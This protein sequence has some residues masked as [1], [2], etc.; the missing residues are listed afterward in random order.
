MKKPSSKSLQARKDKLGERLRRYELDNILSDP[1]LFDHTK[2]NYID[3]TKAAERLL[4]L[5]AVSFTAYNFGESEKVMNWLKTEELWQSV[6]DKEKEFFRDPDPS[7]EE[8]KVLSWRFEGAYVLAWCLEKIEFAPKP[9][10]E[11]GQQQV[12]EFFDQVPAIGTNTAEFFDDLRYR[13]LHEI[14]DESLFYQVTEKYF[15]DLAKKD[16]ENTSSVHAKA[17]V[18]R[19]RVLTWLTSDKPDWDLTGSGKGDT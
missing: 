2:Y 5:L 17:C 15:R 19:F 13:S 9:E 8:K 11:C 14:V 6:S 7:D 3:P 1:E 10:A 18:E 12:A 4:I 16:K